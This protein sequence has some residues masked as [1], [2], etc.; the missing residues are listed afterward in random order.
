MDLH[1]PEGPIRSVR[2]FLV[3]I[4]IVTLGILIALGLEQFIEARHR[5]KIAAEAATGIRH[6]LAD[7]MAQVQE[8]LTAIPGLRTQTQAEIARLSAPPARGSVQA[9]IKYPGVTLDLV[10]SASWDTAIATRALN[11]LPYDTAK[12][13]TAAYGAL[14]LFMDEERVGLDTWQDLHRFGEDPAGLTADQRRALIEQFRR[15]ESYT[16]LIDSIGKTT[17]RVCEEALK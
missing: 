3:H 9:P 14:H 5:A 7:D 12:R 10:S 1:V 15:Y 6:E 8:V 11:D 17:L 4:G 16:H 2:D 13:F